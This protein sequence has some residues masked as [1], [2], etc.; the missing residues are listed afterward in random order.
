MKDG[1]YESRSEQVEAEDLQDLL[2]LIEIKP[3]RRITLIRRARKILRSAA[4]SGACGER[5]RTIELLRDHSELREEI[6]SKS[7]WDVFDGK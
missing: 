6:C 1:F 5:D 4:F 2:K 3:K 7:V